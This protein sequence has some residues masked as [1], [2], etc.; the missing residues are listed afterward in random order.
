VSRPSSL[1][2]CALALVIATPALAQSTT[3]PVART[4]TSR[5]SLGLGVNGT[6]IKG[7]GADEGR[8][9]GGLS[10]SLGWG[11]T[12]KIA[13]VADLAGASMDAGDGE[14]YGLGHG[15]LTARFSF[16][17]AE[18]A[19]VPFV[20]AGLTGR[21]AVERDVTIV[22]DQGNPQTGDLSISGTGF[23]LG[24]G[25]QYFLTP[26][27]ALGAS[28]KWTTGE[29]SRATFQNTTVEGYKTDANS[30]R[31]TLGLSWHPMVGR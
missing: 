30:T 18:H 22:D 11:F 23:T 5:L 10:F 31:F 9:G 19:F 3:D 16:P 25:A 8:S 14:R 26:S 24:G 27:L 2:A 17:R 7:D 1:V 28:L 13:L 12:P 6:A 29:F 21:A 4:H 15:D 20:E